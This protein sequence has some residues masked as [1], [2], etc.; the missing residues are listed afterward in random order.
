[1]IDRLRS[2]NR[3]PGVLGSAWIGEDS[4]IF[5]MGEAIGGAEAVGQARRVAEA[6]R[7][8]LEACPS[9]AT[10]VAVFVGEHGRIVARAAGD[11]TLIVFAMNDAHAGLLR[12]KVR[13][14]TDQAEPAATAA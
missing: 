2:L 13:E 8:W 9:P 10:E 6:F 1:M 5:D 11:G 12:L 3:T 14:A 7:A 4:E